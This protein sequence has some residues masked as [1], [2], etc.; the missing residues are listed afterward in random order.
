MKEAEKVRKIAK[1][2]LFGV[3]GVIGTS[4]SIKDF[5]CQNYIC[6]SLDIIVNVPSA[7]GLV[8]GNIPSTKQ[9]MVLTGAVTVE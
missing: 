1:T 3:D 2:R 4:H 9:F 6:T 8:L 5:G 7:V